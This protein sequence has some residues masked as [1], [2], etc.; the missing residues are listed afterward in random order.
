MNEIKAKDVLL[1]AGVGLGAYALYSILAKKP[2]PAVVK[3]LVVEV[4]KTK[5]TPKPKRK[6]AVKITVA[7]Q[8]AIA[9]I[10]KEKIK[11]P[12]H[13]R[14]P[15]GAVSVV[16]EKAPKTPQEK[17]MAVCEVIET[18]LYS[19]HH[20]R[21]KKLLRT[22]R[23][24]MLERMLTSLFRVVYRASYKLGELVKALQTLSSAELERFAEE[25]VKQAEVYLRTKPIPTA[26]EI[27][28]LIDWALRRLG[29]RVAVPRWINE[30]AVRKAK[31]VMEDAKKLPHP[32]IVGA[33]SGALGRML[34]GI[35]AELKRI[36]K[37]F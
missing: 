33:V 9:R 21:L 29:V 17:A 15:G 11:G 10:I 31:R 13:I 27:E 16:L 36:F 6:E 3:P 12:V 20:D 4:P 18:A 32:V 23:G 35:G 25:F 30:E 1:F 34:A 2:A 8:T 22:Y 37:I 5:I 28:G 7:P 14:Y 19:F 24:S 26:V